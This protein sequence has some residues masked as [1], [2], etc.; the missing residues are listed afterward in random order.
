MRRT[1]R[2]LS[3]VLVAATL[4]A[5]GA[6]VAACASIPCGEKLT[7]ADPGGREF[8]ADQRTQAPDA[9]TPSDD[10]AAPDV[11]SGETCGTTEDCT[12]GIDDNC[13]GLADCA[14]PLCQPGFICAPAFPTG[15]VEPVVV[16]D[17]TVTTGTAP[18]A[19]S[20]AGTYGNNVFDGHY[21]PNAPP[22]TCTCQCG[23]AEGVQCSAPTIQGYFDTACTNLCTGSA[24]VTTACTLLCGDATITGI[25]L[26]QDSSP[27][28]GSCAA[29]VSKRV[30][31]WDLMT[32]WFG[33]ARVCTT[34]RTNY[35]G[36]GCSAGQV[37]VEVP[38]STFGGKV[39]LYQMGH[40]TCPASYSVPHTYYTGGV[41]S[42][43]CG[44]TST[45]S[46]DIP[47]GATCTS[48]VSLYSNSCSATATPVTTT[49]LGL[50]RFG[51]PHASGTVS[52]SGGSCAASGTASPTGDVTPTGE[53]TVCCQP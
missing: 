52:P 47:T 34:A 41:D 37:C 45:C 29:S 6:V 36:G 30:S 25:K 16:Y 5:A 26:T 31:S 1:L 40:Q 15:W 14:D 3:A 10:G 4:S 39:C 20:C 32:G 23:A 33:T 48:S 44:S 12:N 49:C 11:A 24:Q 43:A 17:Q 7:C 46:C 2:C 13:D 50:S 51:G 28:G 9:T 27:S 21:S 18:V 53:S 42:R 35:S 22:A 19:P 8:P 38:P